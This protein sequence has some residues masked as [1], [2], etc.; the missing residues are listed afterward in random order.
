APRGPGAGPP[1]DL[2]P[3]MTLFERA[4]S[5]EEDPTAVRREIGALALSTK[6]MSEDDFLASFGRSLSEKGGDAWPDRD[7][8]CT[9]VDAETGEFIVWDR[10]AKVGISRAV[11]SSCS[12]PGVYPPIT[13]HGRR[14]IDGGMRSGTN[15]D[16]AKGC[17]KVALIALRIGG[18]DGR[19]QRMARRLD[20]EIAVLRAGGAHVELM[21]PDPDS[22]GAFGA[23]LMDFRRRP[24]ACRAGEAQGRALAERLAAFWS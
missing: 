2:S 14:Y 10:A 12:V 6:T 22:S 24:A 17:D 5:G 20:K 9:A 21:L 7:F 18:E 19:A 13:I 8:R 11:A 15:G 1:A 4:W 16:L 23:N 3:L